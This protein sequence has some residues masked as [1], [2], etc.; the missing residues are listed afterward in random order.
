MFMSRFFQP[1]LLIFALGMSG[2]LTAQTANAD[3]KA[4]DAV[5]GNSLAKHHI[6]LQETEDDPQRQTL[7]LNVASNLLQAYGDNVD[8]EV[9]T[10]GPGISLLFA[11]NEHAKRIESLA[12]EGVRFSAC[13]NALKNATE[14]LGHE[15]ALNPVAKKV[16]A[17]I[18][19]VIEL[20]DAGYILV[21]P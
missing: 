14:R 6:V 8:I 5:G 12:Q 11:N 19:R 16:P 21:R 4:I 15:P 10:F 20:V 13:M 18:V 9:V 3:D 17:G 2:L 1:V 7:L